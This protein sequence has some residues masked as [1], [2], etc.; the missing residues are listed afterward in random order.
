MAFQQI[1]GTGLW[2]PHRPMISLSPGINTSVID[3]TGEKVA[4]LGRVFWYGRS[5][6]KDIRTIGLRFGTVVKAGGS[7]LTV[8]LQ[9][10]SAAGNPGV[11]DETQDQT[12]AIANADASFASNTWITTGN[13]SADRTVSLGELLAVVIEFDGS[14][15]L[16]SDSVQ[17][18]GLTSVTTAGWVGGLPTMLLKTASWAGQA[19]VPNV[20]LGFSDG[21][22][23][24]L[25]GS[26]P[27]SAVGLIDFNSGTNPNENALEFS[28][29]FPC[30]VEGGWLFCG[31]TAGSPFEARLY[32]GTS[33]MTNGSVSIDP[34]YWF[35]PSDQC[36]PFTFPG[37]VELAA[38]TTYRLAF[39]PLSG[40]DIRV[41]YFDVATA[42]HFQAHAGGTSWKFN[43]RNGG[44]WGTATDTRR[45]FCG[46][47]V[48]SLSDPS[49]GGTG[50]G[51]HYWGAR[52]G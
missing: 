39:A 51:P 46:L 32:D 45:L 34:G 16:G 10:A 18:T 4:Y 1:P 24:T 25:D 19:R 13:L 9:N 21:T 49:G 50:A 22:F 52:P 23:G 26:W 30:K 3:A 28:L 5:G 33:V 35:N 38:N 7:A 12:V 37:E 6:T 36:V 29:P 20:L 31:G 48:S 47:R 14:G 11:P 15:R 41:R 40:T 44:A 27:V 2:I 8:S 42:N 17:L 43:T